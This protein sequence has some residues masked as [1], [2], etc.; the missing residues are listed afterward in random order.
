MTGKTRPAWELEQEALPQVVDIGQRV[1][2][3][4]DQVGQLAWLYRAQILLPA[5]KPRRVAGGGLEGL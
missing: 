5:Q 4:Q 1:G 3:E 2:V